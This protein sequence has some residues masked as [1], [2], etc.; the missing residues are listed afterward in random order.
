VP[1]SPNNQDLRDLAN[2]PMRCVKEWHTYFVNGYK[3]HIH[4][5]VVMMIFME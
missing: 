4:K 2:R 3:F 1:L 5:R